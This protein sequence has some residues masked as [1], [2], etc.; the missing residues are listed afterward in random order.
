MISQEEEKLDPGQKQVQ[1]EDVQEE[2]RVNV[3][4]RQRE[5]VQDEQTEEGE[6]DKTEKLQGEQTEKLQGEQTEDLIGE[7]TEE[8]QGEQT[9]EPQGEQTEE[10][11]G[12]QT[13][14]TRDEQTEELEDEQTDQEEPKK[15]KVNVVKP[16]AKASVSGIGLMKKPSVRFT[17]PSS[18][19]EDEF[20]QED[21]DSPPVKQVRVEFCICS[22]KCLRRPYC[23]CKKRGAACTAAC[24][25]KNSKCLNK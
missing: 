7:Q 15:E 16:V 1:V 20:H 14:E 9:E 12:E 13:E 5:K 4:K 25:I 10:P 22:S 6:G 21:D 23:R 17:A 3:Q 11:Q 19:L 8:P 24:H 18:S 2:V